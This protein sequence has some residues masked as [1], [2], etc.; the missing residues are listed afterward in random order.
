MFTCCIYVTGW[1]SFVIGDENET[2]CR[3]NDFFMMLGRIGFNK[4]SWFPI[5][6]VIDRIKI[7]LWYY[8]LELFK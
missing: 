7:S 2:A 5:S 8:S 4:G 6:R 3:P 1:Q